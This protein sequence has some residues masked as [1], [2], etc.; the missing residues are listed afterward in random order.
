MNRKIE[1]TVKP[2]W[3]PDPNMTREEVDAMVYGW[4]HYTEEEMAERAALKELDELIPNADPMDADCDNKPEPD[5]EEGF[6]VCVDDF[7]EARQIRVFVKTP[8]PFEH[9]EDVALAE[10]AY[11]RGKAELARL[12]KKLADNHPDNLGE[13]GMP[14]PEGM[15]QATRWIH[16]VFVL[17]DVL[18]PQS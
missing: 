10:A 12:L 11:Q 9:D 7:A 15:K 3:F 13:D 6:W 16:E 2:E 1:V 5:R 17:V 4:T 18:Y 8:T 14:T